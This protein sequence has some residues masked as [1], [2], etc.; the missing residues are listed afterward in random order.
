MPKKVVALAADHAG[1]ALK[2]QLQQWLQRRGYA[3]HDCGAHELVP[4]D[5]YPTYAARAAEAVR[6]I[7]A[8]SV[9]FVC[10]S[11]GGIAMAAN[12]YPW[13]RVVQATDPAVVRMARQDEDANGLSLA[14]RRLTLPQAKR[15]VEAFLKTASSNAARHRRRQKQLRQLP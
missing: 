15:L 13:M 7:P 2:E 12:R 1:F 6:R 8:V 14:S 4:N 3:V 5:D 9:I 10:G 11:G